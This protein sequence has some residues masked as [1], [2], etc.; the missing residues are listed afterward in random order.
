[1]DQEGGS[2]GDSLALSAV[3]VLAFFLCSAACLS[4]FSPWLLV[5]DG[6]VVFYRIFK[7]DQQDKFFK[8]QSQSY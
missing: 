4:S 2:G 8:V 7:H 5:P 6:H 3:V 1:M